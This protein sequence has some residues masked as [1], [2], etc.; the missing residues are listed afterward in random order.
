[1]PITT[2]SLAR[3]A[4]WGLCLPTT[5]LP[6]AIQVMEGIRAHHHH[7]P[8]S[9]CE[10]EALPANYHPPTRDLS[11]GGD[12]CPPPLPPSLETRVTEGIRTQQHQPPS[13]ETRVG[14]FAS[15][16]PPPRSLETRTTIPPTCDSRWRGFAPSSTNLHTHHNLPCSK[17]EWSFASQSPPSSSWKV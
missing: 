1:M 8:R 13:P 6:L 7:L 14:G 11:D 15:Q 2:T 9:K 3:I 4:S 5:T 10:W 12:S 16:P 17:H